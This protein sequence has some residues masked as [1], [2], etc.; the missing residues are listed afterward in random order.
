MRNLGPGTKLRK[1]GPG[2]FLHNLG[3]GTKLQNY[4]LEKITRNTW[5][6]DKFVVQ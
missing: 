2:T 1:K 4:S 5:F 6:L 3:S